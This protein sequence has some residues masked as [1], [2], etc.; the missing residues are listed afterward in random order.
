METRAPVLL[1][2]K[3]MDNKRLEE[4]TG[5]KRGIDLATKKIERIETMRKHKVRVDTSVT[6][7]ITLSD[8]IKETILLLMEAETKRVLAELEEKFENA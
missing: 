1:I 7:S 5:F 2:R 3:K 8:N 4:I 6:S